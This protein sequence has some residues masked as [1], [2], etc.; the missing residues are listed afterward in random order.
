MNA[1]SCFCLLGGRHCSCILHV[2]TS[3]VLCNKCGQNLF[4]CRISVA[5]TPIWVGSD[6]RWGCGFQGEM[7]RPRIHHQPG[8]PTGQH[9]STGR[10]VYALPE[11]TKTLEAAFERGL[12]NP[13]DCSTS[14]GVKG[15]LQYGGPDMGVG[16][17]QKRLLVFWWVRAC[18]ACRTAPFQAFIGFWPAKLLWIDLLGKACPH[19][20]D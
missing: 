10:K 1:R 3:C 14:S 16:N 19:F 8:K 6:C 20:H 2:L 18:G 7:K 11:S 15:W 13:S 4:V 17:P 9:S 5:N 12:C